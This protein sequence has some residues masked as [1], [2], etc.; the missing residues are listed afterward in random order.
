MYIY[1]HTHTQIY[2]Y[3]YIYLY[4]SQTIV[5]SGMYKLVNVY[6]LSFCLI[7]LNTIKLS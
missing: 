6:T 5:N 7:F 4:A 3:I 1:T 2:I